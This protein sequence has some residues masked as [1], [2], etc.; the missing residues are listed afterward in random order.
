[1]NK[2]FIMSTSTSHLT[3]PGP[4]EIPTQV[5]RAVPPIPPNGSLAMP[6]ADPPPSGKKPFLRRRWVMVT[7]AIVAAPVVIAI[8]ASAASS[9]TKVTPAAA[10]AAPATHS[11]PASSAPAAPPAQPTIADW[12]NSAGSGYA[13]TMEADLGKIGTDST[14]FANNLSDSTAEAN[15]AT[16]G[17]KLKAD[18]TAMDQSWGQSPSDNVNNSV[19]SNY[20]TE[21][22]SDY[23]SAGAAL[24]SLPEAG[25][26]QAE[27]ILAQTANS[28]MSAGNT[29]L[30]NATNQI[31]NG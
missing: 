10:P 7:G 3:G 22:L 2:G 25:D 14:T 1:L 29:A 11:P 27:V 21:A 6:P 5:Y 26:V 13:A 4:D 24:E 15:L 23:Q 20:L 18:A 19:F 28:E 8:I 31:K 9:G 12:F 16:D 30:Q 17:T